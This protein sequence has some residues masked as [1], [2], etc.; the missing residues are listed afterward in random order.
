MS[1]P[2]LD[3]N[4]KPIVFKEAVVPEM[5]IRDL[6]KKMKDSGMTIKELAWRTDYSVGFVSMQMNSDGFISSLPKRILNS[7]QVLWDRPA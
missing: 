6:R 4:M 1:Y 2:I 5:L 7:L 3:E